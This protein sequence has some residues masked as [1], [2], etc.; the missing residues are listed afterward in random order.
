MN[1]GLCHLYSGDGKG[2][3]T[4]AMGLALRALG[5]G[6]RVVVVQFLKGQPT[7]EAA[8]LRSLGAQVLRDEPDTKFVFQMDEAEKAACRKAQT[9]RLAQA[10]E[11]PCDVLVLDE[12][13]AACALGMVDEAFL[14]R[15]VLER[16]AGREVVLTGRDPAPWMCE[17]ADY[18]TQ[19]RCVRHPYD[20]GVG[21]RKGIEY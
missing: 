19:M 12:A 11:M 3:T 17:A 14:R 21:A 13:C 16:P 4:A 8:L 18:H 9:Q 20:A 5:N 15:A 6:L 7:G 2:K 10:L 1:K